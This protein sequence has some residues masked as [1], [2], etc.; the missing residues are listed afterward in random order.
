MVTIF[1]IIATIKWRKALCWRSEA[2]SKGKCPQDE[3][4]S[5]NMNERNIVINVVNFIKSLTY[6]INC[7][8]VVIKRSSAIVSPS[9]ISHKQKIGAF[10]L[11]SR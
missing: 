2:T 11:D 9:L 10:I 7:F 3:M 4:E 8:Y 6:L 5:S 1:F